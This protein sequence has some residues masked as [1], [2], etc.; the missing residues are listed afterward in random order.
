MDKHHSPTRSHLFTI[1]LWVEE[2]APLG[3]RWQ[4]KLQDMADGHIAYF[5][6]LQTLVALLQAVLLQEP[7]TPRQATP[8]A[9]HD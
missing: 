9:V 3:P 6:D 1:R 5:E 7:A 4:G 2:S 8:P